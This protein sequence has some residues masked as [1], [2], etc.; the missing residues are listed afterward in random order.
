[1]NKNTLNQ[2]NLDSIEKIN[3]A[4]SNWWQPKIEKKQ[5]KNL[6]K[7]SDTKAWIHTLIYFSSLIISGYIAYLSWGTWWSIPAFIIYGTIYAN[8]N[9]RWHEYGHRTAFRTRGLNEFFYEISAF[10]A[11]FEPV[12]W[13]LSHANHHSKTRHV[14]LDLEIADPRPVKLWPIFFTEFFGY[15]RIKAESIKIIKHSFRNF[16]IS[17]DH[18]ENKPPLSVIDLVPKSQI[19]RMVWTS[20]VFLLIILSTI[21]YSFYLRSVIPLF[22]VV[23]PQ[24]YGGPILWILAFPQH[25]GLKFNSSD[26]RETTRTLY[27]GPILGYFLYSNMQ[28]HIEH[29]VFPQ[30]PFYNL[31]KLH[32]LIKSQLPKSNRGLIDAYWE[33][34]PAMLKQSKDSTYNIEKELPS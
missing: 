17:I 25:A 29:H 7:R 5:L 2:T 4:N 22:F 3:L 11:F 13:R 12:S 15:Y 33:I 9:S 32:E 21:A 24:I 14:D 34:I 10:L 18:G 6:M 23:T 26:H 30:V 27:L 16:K 8:S 1:M 20:R 31:P 28:Y 19:N